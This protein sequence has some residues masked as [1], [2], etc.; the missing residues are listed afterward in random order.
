[1]DKMPPLLMATRPLRVEHQ[2]LPLLEVFRS[3]RRVG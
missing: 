3:S 2:S 1:M